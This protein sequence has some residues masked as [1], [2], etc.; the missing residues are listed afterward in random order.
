MEIAVLYSNGNHYAGHEH[1][2]CLLHVLLA[3]FIGSHDAFE[4]RLELAH[5]NFNGFVL[6]HRGW[7]KVQQVSTQ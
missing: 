4:R 5:H 2:I 6:T 7:E 1:Q 3:N